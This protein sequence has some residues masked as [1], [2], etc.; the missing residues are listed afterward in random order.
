MPKTL[1]NEDRL[2]LTRSYR[3]KALKTLDVA[4]ELVE[5]N[6]TELEQNRA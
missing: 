6:L 2:Y 3:E 4:R 1:D 5:K